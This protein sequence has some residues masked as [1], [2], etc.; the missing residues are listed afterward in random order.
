M[1]KINDNQIATLQYIVTFLYISIWVY[2]I[3]SYRTSNF[4]GNTSNLS[5][6]T[7][8]QKM[9]AE[10]L[11]TRPGSM[12]ACQNTEHFKKDKKLVAALGGI[13]FSNQTLG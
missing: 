6:N 10:V 3:L 8:T 12:S 13:L 1:C 4:L 2:F 11:S 5:I 9:Y 7:N